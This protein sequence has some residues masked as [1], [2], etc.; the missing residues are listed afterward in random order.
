MGNATHDPL[1]VMLTSKD[2]Q[3]SL[4]FYREVLGFEVE[5]AWPS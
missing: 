2:M 4:A 1:S 5:H 3:K